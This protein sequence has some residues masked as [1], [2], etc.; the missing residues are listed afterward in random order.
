LQDGNQAGG[1]P[2]LQRSYRSPIFRWHNAGD[3]HACSLAS[4]NSDAALRSFRLMGFSNGGNDDSSPWPTSQRGACHFALDVAGEFLSSDSFFESSFSAMKPSCH[5]PKGK[6]GQFRP[7]LQETYHLRR[8]A[9]IS[10][11]LIGLNP[12]AGGRGGCLS[13]ESRKTAATLFL[14]EDI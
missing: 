14:Q 13:Q 3:L 6:N 4:N 5:A 1:S 9:R 11:Q 2:L 12:E 7:V 10:W 8:H